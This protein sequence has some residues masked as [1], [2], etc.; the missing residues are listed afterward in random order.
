[1]AVPGSNLRRIALETR[2]THLSVRVGSCQRHLQSLSTSQ[3]PTS[4]G[5]RALPP[6]GSLTPAPKVVNLTK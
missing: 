1:M 3:I 2:L 5:S 4:A 6:V